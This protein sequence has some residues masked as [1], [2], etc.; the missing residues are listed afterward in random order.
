MFS[1]LFSKSAL[2]RRGLLAAAFSLGLLSAQAECLIKPGDRVAINGD[3]ITAQRMYS[4]FLEEYLLACQPVPNLKT[5]NFGTGGATAGYFRDR[6]ETDILPFKPNVSTS[7]FGM[8]DGHYQPIRK[9][10]QDAYR[11]ALL[12]A[13]NKL[14][15][16]GVQTFFVAG[17]GC[18]DPAIFKKETVSADDYNAT[19]KDLSG[20]A[21][22]VAGQIG[23]VFVDVHGTM[24]ET[25]TRAKAAHASEA[26]FRGGDGVHPAPT[27]HLAMAYAF[28]KAIGCDGAIGTITVDLAA[29]KAEATPG[30]K[31]VSVNQGAVTVE[32][33]R[34]PFCFVGTIDASAVLPY[35]PF[36]Q[37]LNRYQLVVKGLRAPSAKVTWGPTSKQFTAEQLAQGINLAA[38]FLQNPFC[39]KFTALQEAV[40]CQQGIEQPMA[41]DL[42]NKF[43]RLAAQQP[44]QKELLDGITATCMDLQNKVSD[45]S[46][47]RVVPVTHTIK[48][49]PV[50]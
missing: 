25:M 17:P 46:G 9:E 23:G 36:N 34:Y 20:I 8:N 13:L 45:L 49:E 28:L 5:D 43:K 16:A 32:S 38:E 14:K 47:G 22:E 39:E 19:L 27:S 11:T 50:L 41:A 30:H 26:F 37:D 40:L 35:L 7:C 10:N 2:I 15:A 42:I 18:V 6:I 33:S 21:R 4:V 1:P 29:N 12:A 24:F 3:S 31:I 44:D 48:I